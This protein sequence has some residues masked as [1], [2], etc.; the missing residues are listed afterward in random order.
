MRMW[1]TTLLVLATA[2]C[3][4]SS[5]GGTA[6]CAGDL[7]DKCLDEHQCMSSNCHNFADRSFTAC[8][9]SCTVGDDS[10]CMATADGVKATCV[11]V[12][13]AN[14]ICTPHAV[15]DCVLGP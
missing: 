6:S 11:A 9:V 3:A 13:G 8:S 5:P 4:G 15:N 10:P 7:Y 2:A 1:I 12:S 14:G